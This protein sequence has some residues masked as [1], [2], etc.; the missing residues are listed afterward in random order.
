MIEMIIYCFE[1]S[2][3]SNRKLYLN[4]T[5]YNLT[6]NSQI[7]FPYSGLNIFEMKMNN[8]ALLKV[9]LHG[10]FEYKGIE[11]K[12]NLEDSE[13]N[14]YWIYENKIVK[15]EKFFFTEYLVKDLEFII[16][17][18]GESFK[19]NNSLLKNFSKTCRAKF[20]DVNCG[21]NIEEYSHNTRIK[22]IKDDFSIE[23]EDLQKENHYFDEGKL[24]VYYNSE[25]IIFKIIKQI[26]NILYIDLRGDLHLSI[27][28][29]SNQY[30]VKLIP[31]CNKN[32]STCA[33]K[34]KNE[35]NF[36]GEP[37]IPDNKIT[38]R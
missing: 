28:Q 19:Y 15:K 35:L 23:L 21:A 16:S 13:W 9:D 14:I 5:N 32:F 26:Q 17:L 33:N 8:F 29:I 22:S 2:L 25:E 37:F 18:N 6:I 31:N 30:Y 36:R 1:I 24:V 11:N 4:S 10:I 38:F 20:G 3:K 27:L 12:T 34:F 7:Y